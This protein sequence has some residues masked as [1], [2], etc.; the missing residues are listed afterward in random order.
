MIFSDTLGGRRVSDLL[1]GDAVVSVFPGRW[2]L[3][4]CSRKLGQ[5][6]LGPHTLL[7]ALT[8]P[9]GLNSFTKN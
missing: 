8:L 3:C 1:S 5:P 4:D 9:L 7:V 2:A 6:H